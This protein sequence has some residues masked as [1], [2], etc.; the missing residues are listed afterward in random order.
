MECVWGGGGGG[1]L[2]WGDVVTM[3]YGGWGTKIYANGKDSGK[4]INILDG[5][6]LCYFA[7]TVGSSYLKVEVTL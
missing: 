4:T 2:A 3:S 7:Y 1:G 6:G 5:L